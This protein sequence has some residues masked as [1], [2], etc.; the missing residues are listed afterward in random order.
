MSDDGNQ[1]HRPNW[2]SAP[3]A[4]ILLQFIT[5]RDEAAFRCLVERYRGLVM[6]VCRSI[7]S[8]THDADDAFQATFLILAQRAGSIRRLSSFAGWLQRVA[9]R[10]AIGLAKRRSKRRELPLKHDLVLPRTDLEAIQRR[11]LAR[12][13]HEELGA[14]PQRLRDALIL[15]HLE[16][17][18][19]RQAAEILECTESAVKARL[20]RGRKM[21]RMRLMR[22]G[23][24]LSVGLCAIDIACEHAMAATPQKLV[25]CTVEIV[26]DYT[27]TQAASGPSVPQAITIANTGVR[28]M[29]IRSLVAPTLLALMLALAGGTLALQPAPA[30]SDSLRSQVVQFVNRSQAPAGEGPSRAALVAL[31]PAQTVKRTPSSSGHP[32]QQEVLRL[33]LVAAEKRLEAAKLQLQ[34]ISATDAAVSEKAQENAATIAAEAI[35]LERRSDLLRLASQLEREGKPA[36]RL[37]L[38][39]AEKRLIAAE[40]EVQLLQTAE[41]SARKRLQDNVRVLNAEANVAECEVDVFVSAG[42]LEQLMQRAREGADSDMGHVPAAG[43]QRAGSAR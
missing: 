3:D 4:D 7:L 17:I 31:G 33:Q 27:S 32:Q 39:A 41:S 5:S 13:I 11:E 18:S 14:I 15:C 19:R 22:R 9:Y 40:S 37:R 25:S 30:Q 36:I 6:G 26:S 16:G 23:I 12:T 24:S 38:N 10:T 35:V 21:L 8:S 20:A 42:N 2:E 34:A 43:G 29:A 28:N 1:K